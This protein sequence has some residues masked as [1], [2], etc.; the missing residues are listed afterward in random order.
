MDCCFAN[1]LYKC[2]IAAVV[3]KWIGEL[4]MLSSKEEVPERAKT[5]LTEWAKAG[6]SA[7]AVA[8]TEVP[9]QPSTEEVK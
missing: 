9:N 2:H 1:P 8:P 5:M 7:E 4:K 3:K 6:K